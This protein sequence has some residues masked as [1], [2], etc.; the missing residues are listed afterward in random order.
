[1]VRSAETIHR[2]HEH[3]TCSDTVTVTTHVSREHRVHGCAT[4]LPYPKATRV[5]K[6]M[7]PT[8][9]KFGVV[10]ADT[11]IVTRILRSKDD[12]TSRTDAAQLLQ[13]VAERSVAACLVKGDEISKE[14]TDERGSRL[15][16]GRHAVVDLCFCGIQLEGAVGEFC[17]ARQPQHPHLQAAE[18][19]LRRL[20]L[21]DLLIH[22]YQ[23]PLH[24]TGRVV[25]PHTVH[26]EKIIACD[27]AVYYSIYVPLHAGMQAYEHHHIPTQC[28][29]LHAPTGIY[30]S[31]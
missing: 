27:L 10:C 17:V 3:A 4:P 25:C 14:Y 30:S 29:M 8:M 31:L 12:M 20:P 2:A 13:Y 9:S 15:S 16:E 24:D 19:L 21:L 7:K 18:H 5:P 1:M 11:T 22:A 28:R 23:Q 26:N 6:Y